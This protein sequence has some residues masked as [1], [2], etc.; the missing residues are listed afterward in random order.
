[1]RT[2]CHF[3]E[4]TRLVDQDHFRGT[5]ILYINHVISDAVLTALAFKTGATMHII[6]V[7]YGSMHSAERQWV[8]DEYRKIGKTL[9]PEIEDPLEFRT[10]MRASVEEVLHDLEKTSEPLLIVEDGGYAFP[11]MH[12]QQYVSCLDRTLGAVEHTAR[13]MWNY[14]FMEVDGEPRT[15]RILNKP[16]LT[17]A[18]S[19]L[20]HAHEPPFVAQ[21]VMH[22]LLAVLKSQNEFIQFKNATILDT[23]GWEK[24]SL[25]C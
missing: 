3:E 15:P 7:P 19:R 17:I 21:G 10:K 16:A 12:E 20:K 25:I 1:M 5:R 6:G 11:V 9:I 14:Q 13:G 24:L 2:A 8:R 18:K 4:Y 22:E 23:V